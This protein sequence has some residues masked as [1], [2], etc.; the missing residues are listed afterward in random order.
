MLASDG[1][2]VSDQGLL[3]GSEL[4]RKRLSRP[5][6][7]PGTSF[8]PAK[9]VGRRYRTDAPSSPDHDAVGLFY[10]TGPKLQEL[11]RKYRPLVSPLREFVLRPD[12][13]L[14][15]HV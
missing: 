15:C 13:P 8:R 12:T 4:E 1:R 5:E 2:R 10:T 11:S 9:A 3:P 7:R 14:D 6:T